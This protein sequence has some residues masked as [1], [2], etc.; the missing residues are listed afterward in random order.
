ME[1][2]L[3]LSSV[4]LWVVVVCN[5][6]LTLALVRRVNSGSLPQKGLKE[7]QPAPNFTAETL[8][9]QTVT[10]A[11]YAQR[12]VAFVF[13]EPACGPCREALPSY[14]AL[15]PKAEQSGVALMLVS[16]ADA[17]RTRRFVDEFKIK[18]PII[19]APRDSNPFMKDYNLSSTPSYCL[20][21]RQGKVQ[22]AGLPSLR[23]GKWKALAEAW[24]SNT[25]HSASLEITE[26]IERR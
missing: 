10:L 2:F 17:E 15:G 6:V 21:D 9:G 5:L 24:E 23:W 12:E 22:A 26:T 18:L 8:R 25:G 7:G 13:V 20:I 1:P 3:V 11:T 14:E 4:M 19:I 16:T